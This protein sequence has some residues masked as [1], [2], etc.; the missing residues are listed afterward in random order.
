MT[1]FRSLFF[2]C[3]LLAP[4]SG[5]A[6][7]SKAIQAAALSASAAVAEA[8]PLNA[9]SVAPQPHGSRL[10][11]GLGYPD[12]RLRWEAGNGWALEAKTSFM[13]GL[14][15]Y[16]GR[17]NYTLGTLG[18]VKTVVGGELAWLKFDGLDT[19]SGTGQSAQAYFGLELPFAGRWGLQAD[20]GPLWVQLTSEGQSVVA[21]DLVFN[22]ALYFYIW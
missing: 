6:A 18:A 11:F 9:S 10:A 14:Q 12:Q 13:E 17:V 22:A 5:A 8:A 1:L 20:A 4:L 3:A 7:E 2:A 16:G 19:M 21:S 15:T